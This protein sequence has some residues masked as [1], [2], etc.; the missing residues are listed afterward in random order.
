MSFRE[1]LMDKSKIISFIL[2]IV[3]LGIGF[4]AYTFYNEKLSLL[5]ANERI[6]REK[7]ALVKENNDL[8]YKYDK[9]NQE[10]EDSER[11]LLAI[12]DEF[13]RVQEDV[14]D[15]KYKWE[16]VSRERDELAERVQRVSVS[17]VSVVD[18]RA[19][20]TIVPEDHWV[21]FVEKKANLEASITD[22]NSDLLDAKN[23][24]AEL[25]R[26]NKELSIKLDQLDKDK[27]A[28]QDNIKFKERAMRI[29]SIDLVN[30]REEKGNAVEKLETVRSENI[31]LKRE[32]VMASKEKV[33]LQ[34]DYQQ[35]VE[36]KIAVENQIIDMENILK[37]KSLAL[38]QLQSQLKQT[39]ARGAMTP[40][41]VEL[42]PIVVK[43]QTSGLQGI[44]GEVIAINMDE[45]FIVVDIGESSGL[46]PGVLLKV[47]RAGR[48]IGE[49]EVI[50]T[51][52]EISAADIKKSVGGYS[53][54]EGDLV[55]SK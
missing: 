50:E 19:P 25:Q 26:D 51:R 39:I 34:Q 32:L 31:S 9:A 55:I 1:V 36:K 27:Q 17:E 3:I 48:E 10:K 53:I 35:A 40:E 54:Q 6:K 42:P 16:E 44:Q 12:Q 11:R 8:K 15:W 49:V 28:L 33:E 52:R 45:K 23:K 4:V 46:R 41:S 22:L 18:K 37:S 47:M 2:L 30:E 20:T 13:E 14:E 43:P 29:M 24:I 38:E 5:E 7:S 21:D